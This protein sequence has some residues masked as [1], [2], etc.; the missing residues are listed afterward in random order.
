[1]LFSFLFNCCGESWQ[2]RL[3]RVGLK[4]WW[5]VGG[6]R[7]GGRIRQW[8]GT[9][10]LA[11]SQKK[12]FWRLLKWIVRA[13]QSLR[14]CEKLNLHLPCQRNHYFHFSGKYR[15]VCVFLFSIVTQIFLDDGRK[16]YEVPK[17]VSLLDFLN[18]TSG[19]QFFKED[20]RQQ[21]LPLRSGFR[22]P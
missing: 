8:Q 3:N 4:F 14:F 10:P 18:F 15:I 11:K 12:S 16:I 2:E 5:T 13:L 20:I 6:G 9:W 17:E 21:D 1:M 7:W 19:I 22:D